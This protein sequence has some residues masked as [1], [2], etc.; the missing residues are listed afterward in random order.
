MKKLYSL[1]AVILLAAGLLGACGSDTNTKQGKNNK[2]QEPKSSEEAKTSS[3]PVT[4]K[5]GTDKEV[6]I[7]EKPEKVVSLIP[8]NTEILYS[9]GAGDTVVG[10]SEHDNYPEEAAE[11]EKV[12]GMEL[13]IEKIIS[14][15]PDLVLAHGSAASMWE[16]GLKQLEDSGITVLVVPDAQSFEKVYETID[17]IGKATGHDKEAA[18]VVSGMKEKLEEIKKK[19]ADI[20]ENERKSVF[21]EVSPAPEIYATG[22]NTF[23]NEM[24]AAVNAENTVKE[25]GWVKMNEEAIIALNPDV[26]ITT[27]GYIENAADQVMERKGWQDVTAVKEKQVREVDENK[28]SRSGP[29]IVEG[30]EE[31]AKA[32]YPDVFGE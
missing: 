29:R 21:V 8:S 17:M 7:E 18:E 32:I 16:A 26:I 30:V 19:A 1:F 10:V 11:K 2:Q 5:D 3:F 24:L 14:L 12:A 27:Y 9:V 15:K 20:P 4:I 28:V 23:M 13:N 6:V 22:N 31:L 25:D